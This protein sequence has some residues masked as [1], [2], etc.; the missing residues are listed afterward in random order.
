MCRHH[1]Q[2]TIFHKDI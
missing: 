2:R 1:Y